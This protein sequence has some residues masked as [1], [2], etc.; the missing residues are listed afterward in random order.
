M[1]IGLLHPGEMGAAVGAALVGIGHEV[2]WVTAGRSPATTARA[3]A[4]GLLGVPSV[5]ELASASELIISVC[6]PH[7]ALDV[8]ASIGPWTGIYLDANA[9][10]PDRAREV[11]R[12]IVDGGGRFVDGGIVGPPPV[13]PGTTRLYV[14]GPDAVEVTEALATPHI[15][16]HVV[17]EW[18]GAAS[19][20]KLAYAAWTKGTAALLLAIRSVAVDEGVDQW[21]VDEWRTSQPELADRSVRAARSALTKGWRW[22]GEMEEIAA[23]M[24]AHALPGGFHEAAAEIYRRVPAD[25]S[26]PPGAALDTVRGLLAASPGAKPKPATPEG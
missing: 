9:I 20:L 19:A 15:E 18:P 25:S 6:P 14:S 10:S 24:V 5:A 4:A 23:M 11:G 8:A 2:R 17:S 21:L 26:V 7:A 1:R 16:S 3:E 13:Q 22:Q 12:I